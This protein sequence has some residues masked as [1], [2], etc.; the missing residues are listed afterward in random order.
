MTPSGINDMGGGGDAEYEPDPEDANEAA[1]PGE[2]APV[3]ELCVPTQAL[4]MPDEQDQLATPEPG[5]VVTLQVEGKVSRVEGDNA[6]VTPSSVNGQPIGEKKPAE[7][8]APEQQDQADYS[9]LQDMAQQQGS[10]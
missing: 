3:G 8:V 7:P 1:E 2:A 4:A 5:D 6:Y 9:Q 10:M